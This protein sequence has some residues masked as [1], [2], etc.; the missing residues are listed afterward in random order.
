MFLANTLSRASIP[1]G[2]Q[3]VPEFETINMMKYL[4]ISDE[5][6][7]EIQRETRSDESLQVLTAVIHQGWQSRK[8]P[9]QTSSHP[10]LISEMRCRFRM[11]WY[12]EEKGWLSHKQ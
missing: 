7:Q 2:G 5:R 8:T 1:N 4:P 9:F 11:V 3:G 6:L 12:L 10:T